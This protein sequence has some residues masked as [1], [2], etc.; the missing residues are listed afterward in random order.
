MPDAPSD[1]LSDLLEKP[2]RFYLKRHWRVATLG[3]TCLFITNALETMIP[4]LVG[5]ALDKIMQGSDLQRVGG[6][7]TQ[8]I[9]IIIF[10]SMFRYLWRIFWSRFHHTVAED[11]RNRVYSHLTQM[12]PSFFKAHKI[13]QLTTLISNDVNSFRMGVGPGLL[14]LLDGAC[15]FFLILPVML[16]ISP[17][18]TW[19]TLAL[20]PFVPFVV[21][22]ILRKLH[23]EYHT[24]QERFGDMSGSAQEIVSGIRVI[25]SFAQEDAQ[26]HEFNRHS[27][28]FRKACN[29]VAGCDALF[30]PALELPVALGSV[31][32]LLLGANEVISGEITIG[33]FF[34]FYQYIQRMI[35]PMDALGVGMS[36]VQESRASFRRL[37]EV[38]L[39]QPDVIDSGDIDIKSIDS[40]ELRDLSFTYP[41]AKL[42]ALDRISFTLRKGESLGVIGMTGSGKSTLVDLLLRQYPAP[43][44]SIFI[45]GVPVERIRVSALRKLI[46]FVPQEAFLFSR[47]VAENLALGL[48]TWQLADVK[49]AAASVQ[50]DQEIESWSEGYDALIGE[51]GVNLSGGQKQRLTLARALIRD[52]ELVILDDSLS[53]VDAKTEER[54]LKGLS[55]ELGQRTSIIVSHRLASVQ[56]TDFCLVLKEGRVEAIGPLSE[57]LQSSPTFQILSE[58]QTKSKPSHLTAGET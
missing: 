26:T 27:S 36:H 23:R 33:Q 17:T 7:I 20:M 21:R 14:I 29:R 24:R 19:Q 35:W 51:R 53:A 40:I 44:G 46:A 9:L 18:W 39:T 50:L 41:G 30:G 13:G 55:G 37:R 34:A 48:D 4:L 1:R 10:L 28:G 38:L 32:L 31:L 3:L 2:Y 56:H 15:I 57:L 12:G 54:I 47:K 6:V 52:S 42:R 49:R 11:L 8:I 58:M 25:K 5:R 16:S 43:P 45:N 22:A